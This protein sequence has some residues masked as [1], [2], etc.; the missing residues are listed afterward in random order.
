MSTISHEAGPFAIVPL[1]VLDRLVAGGHTEALA[2]YVGLHKWSAG[3]DRTCH[4]SRSTIAKYIGVNIKSVDRYV[5]HLEAIGALTREKRYVND[6]DQTSNN[7]TIRIAPVG[8]TQESPLPERGDTGVA[9]PGDTGVA[10]TRPISNQTQR[11]SP[12]EKSF[13]RVELEREIQ[14]IRT[15]TPQ[16]RQTRAR[17]DRLKA[18]LERN[19]QPPIRVAA[20]Y[21]LGEDQALIR[22]QAEQAATVGESSGPRLSRAERDTILTANRAGDRQ[23]S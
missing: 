3:H 17:P 11:V 16:M 2:L 10:L 5:G 23:H 21:V 1:W 22:W 14:S 18:M 12:S 8:G 13:T 15:E 9:P 20:A 19:P 4:P 7:Y 6:G